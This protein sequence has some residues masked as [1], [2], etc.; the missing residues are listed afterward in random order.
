MAR[1]IFVPAL[2]CLFLTSVALAQSGQWLPW[3]QAGSVRQ[4]IYFSYRWRRSVPCEPSGKNNCSFEL[5]LRNDSNR[6]ESVNY[7]VHLETDDGQEV[8]ERDHRN[9]GSGEVQDIPT[10]HYGRI[11][12]AVVVE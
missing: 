9:F 2:V 8:V 6:Q 3:A 11:I 10:D 1:K 7:T 5:Q 12:T 4:R